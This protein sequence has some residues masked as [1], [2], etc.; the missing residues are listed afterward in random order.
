MWSEAGCLEGL[1]DWCGWGS[2]SRLLSAVSR[3]QSPGTGIERTCCQAPTSARVAAVIELIKSMGDVCSVLLRQKSVN[4]TNRYAT[5]MHGNDLVIEAGKTA[6]VLG[7]HNRR[8]ATVAVSGDVR[9][10][11]SVIGNKVLPILPLRWQFDSSGSGY[12]T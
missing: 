6:L 10:K 8:K 5:D 9:A 11:R 7:D 4:L 12:H 1:G 2:L 3:K